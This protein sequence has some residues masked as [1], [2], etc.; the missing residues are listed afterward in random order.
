MAMSNADA[1]LVADKQVGVNGRDHHR[2]VNGTHDGYG[3]YGGNPLAREETSDSARYPAF[4]GEF[5]PGTYRPRTKLA[6]PAPLG[7]SA[8]A[9]TTFILS[10]INMNARGVAGP[11]IVVASAYGYGGLVQ[12]LAGMVSSHTLP[13]QWC[14]AD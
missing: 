1:T 14:T 13:S 6:N 2:E 8:F 11:N 10:L 7:L 3:R 4:G 12:L 9:L 5:Q